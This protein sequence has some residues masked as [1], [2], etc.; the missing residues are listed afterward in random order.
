MHRQAELAD[1]RFAGRLVAAN[2]PAEVFD[3]DIGDLPA[4]RD[5]ELVAVD[6]HAYSHAVDLR[7]RA[8]DRFSAYRFRAANQRCHNCAEHGSAAAA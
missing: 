3:V 1:Q 8:G 4:G 7:N 5:S 6:Y 2:P